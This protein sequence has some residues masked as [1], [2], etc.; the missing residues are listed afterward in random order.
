MDG[1]KKRRLCVPGLVAFGC[2]AADKMEA[3]RLGSDMLKKL[4]YVTDGF[5]DSVIK[6]EMAVSTEVGFGFAIPHGSPKDVRHSGIA[7]VR[8]DKAVLWH[9]GEEVD[10][11]F[12]IAACTDKRPQDMD[13]LKGFY[14]LLAVLL[15]EEEPRKR[16]KSLNK[17]QDI[18]NYINGKHTAGQS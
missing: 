16:F 7:V 12:L 15:D 5:V 4:G 9:S 14:K 17:A 18:C 1:K 6:R 8:L 13:E 3:I 10:T 11:I 2:S